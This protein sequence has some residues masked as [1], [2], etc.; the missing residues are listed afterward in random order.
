MAFAISFNNTVLPVF[1]CATSKPLCP[2]PI[3]DTRSITLVDRSFGFTSR[4]NLESG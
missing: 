2:L 3:G 4:L 1:G